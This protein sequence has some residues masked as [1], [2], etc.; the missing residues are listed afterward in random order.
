MLAC[1][2]VGQSSC[3]SYSSRAAE[4]FASELTPE[5]G[6]RERLREQVPARK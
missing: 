1:C 4:D 2:T 6:R 5:P 3:C